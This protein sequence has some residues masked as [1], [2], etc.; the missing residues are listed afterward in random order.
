M[1]ATRQTRSAR[2]ESARAH[3]SKPPKSGLGWQSDW[4]R[5]DFHGDLKAGYTDYFATPAASG[6]YGS[7]V[8][9]V[10]VD[11]TRDLSFDAEGRFSFAPQP[12]SNF[13]LSTSA[14]GANPY[15]DVSTFGATLGGADKFGDLTL[16]LHGSVDRESYQ[17][18]QLFG[19][20]E[21]NLSA[22]DYNDYALHARASYR[23]SEVLSPFTEFVIDERLYDGVTD[24]LGYE[25]NSTGVLGRLGV[26]VAFSQMVTGEA[27]VGYGERNYQ[28][29]RLPHAETPLIDA[30]LIW[31]MTPLTTLTLKAQSALNDSI[32]SGASADIN[33]TYTID[34]SHALTRA[35]TIGLDGSYATDEYVGS[36]ATRHDDVAWRQ[37]GIPSQSR[38]R[39]ES[40]RDAA[41]LWLQPAQL[42]RC[43]RHLP[44]RGEGP[45]LNF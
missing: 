11:A 28:D 5:N 17:D 6:D 38:R 20:E 39:V 3:C 4:S 19:D 34:L 2:R 43:Q 25:R 22:D 7:G 37:G 42:E 14:N 31:A 44:V 24:A 10:R 41:D 26:T 12:L 32:L 36:T 27:S 29:P 9:D 1:S 16:G 8:A 18:T 33:H 35:L 21:G 15:I 13:G 45:A 23:I 30:S 40:E